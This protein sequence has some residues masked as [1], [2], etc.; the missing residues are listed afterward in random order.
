MSDRWVTLAILGKTRGN[1]GELTAVGFSKPERYPGLKQ[2]FLFAPGAVTGVP[3]VVESVWQHGERLI[4]KFIG[5]DS[6]S[7][8]ERLVGSEV[9]LPFAERLEPEPGEYFESD[10]V[11]CE[12]VER[13]GNVLGRVTGWQDGGG[14]RLLIVNDDLLIPFVKAICVGIDPAAGKI[15]VEL[16]EGLKDLNRS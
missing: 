13:S 12:V 3:R 6:I 4:F 2:V 7:D 14:P 15:V 8:A 10:L 16:P 11:G 5:V 1:R 9:R